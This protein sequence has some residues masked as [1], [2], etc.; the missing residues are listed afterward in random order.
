[1]PLNGKSDIPQTHG[2]GTQAL[3]LGAGIAG[4]FAARVLAEY[5]DQVC[6][7]ERDM[8]PEEPE[9]R[10]GTPQAFHLHHLLFRGSVIIERLFPGYVDELLKHGAFPSQ[11][12]KMTFISQ[13]GR[14]DIVPQQKDAGCSRALL[15]WTIRRRVQALA[16]VRFLTRLEVIG[17]HTS[18]DRTCVD[19]IYVRSRGQLEQHEALMADL[20][21][22]T[23]GR[24]SKVSPWVKALGYEVPEPERLKSALGYTTRYYKVSPQFAQKRNGIIIIEG[25]PAK[26]IRTS[27]SA[28]IEKD[29]FGVILFSA[30]GFYP[31]TDEEGF[32]QG[33]HQLLSQELVDALQEA[34]PVTQPRGYRILE[35]LRQHY[36]QMERW[37]SGLLVMG[38][39]FCNVDPIYGQGMSM[40]AIEAE[41]LETCLREQ[42]ERPQ[43]DF[44]RRFFQR[45]QDATEPAWWLSAIA[46]RRWPGVEYA[47]PLSLEGMTLAQKYFDLYLKQARWQMAQDPQNPQS[48]GLFMKY[49]MMNGLMASPREIVN[50]PMIATLL[51]ADSSSDE[52]RQL[53]QFLNTLS[54]EYGQSFEQIFDEIVPT[55]ERFPALDEE[56]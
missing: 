45:M 19:G 21:I 31:P 8:L 50:P 23:S 18:P 54:R 51:E 38:D 47:G 46:D 34:E 2:S 16:N 49:M 20:I 42:R 56:F 24:S 32:D 35:C 22:D 17:F 43:P 48:M 6:V 40:A 44:E 55:F 36:G 12:Q 33:L 25:Q 26:Q 9:N 3:V 53:T 15:E 27:Y 37:P 10:P 5:Y 52:G 41:M 29:R 14:Q 30:G 13:H 7:V 39:A 1:M 11:N 28:M 4:L